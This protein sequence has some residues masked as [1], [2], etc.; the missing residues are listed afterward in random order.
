MTI[1][2]RV[3]DKD[4]KYVERAAMLGEFAGG[5]LDT[6]LN[7]GKDGGRQDGWWWLRQWLCIVLIRRAEKN[8]GNPEVADLWY[9]RYQ[10]VRG[11]K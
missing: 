7:D 4:G 1:N 2:I 5:A 6:I 10:A 9:A 3:Q 8:S 11:I